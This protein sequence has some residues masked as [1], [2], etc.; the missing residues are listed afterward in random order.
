MR[1]VATVVVLFL[2]FCLAL[3]QPCRAISDLA[4]ARALSDDGE[5]EKAREMLEQLAENDEKNA[6]VMFELGKAW[7]FLRD[8]KKATSSLEKAIKIQPDSA[9]YHL[10]LGHSFGA[11]TMSGSKLKAMFRARKVPDC[12]SRAVELD[13]TSVEARFSLFQFHT[14]APGIAGGDK[15][16]ARTQIIEIGNLNEASGHLAQAILSFS[17]KDTAKAEEYYLKAVDVDPEDPD[18]QMALGMFH[19]DLKRYDQALEIF[20]QVYEADPERSNALYQIGK[21]CLLAERDLDRAEE[22]FRKYLRCKTRLGQPS[23]AAA[24][25]RLGQIYEVRGDLDGAEAE[26]KKGLEL[27]SGF[28]YIKNSLKRLEKK[29]DGE[30]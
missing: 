23:K 24:Y 30:S 6:E 27:D 2:V 9:K 21:T 22:S 1:R 15:E 16:V 14:M 19:L 28:E 20:E 4:E 25:W 8:Y 3:S 13:P 10:W 18:F 29:R 17:E 26:W 12:Y 11:L 7:Y 5:Y